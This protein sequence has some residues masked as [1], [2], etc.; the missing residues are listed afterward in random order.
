MALFWITGSA[1]T[2]KTTICKKLKEKGYVSYDIDDD[3]LARW[4]NLK[5]G[6]THP[7]SSVSK[8]QRTAEFIN[9]HGWFVPRSTA[10]E[11]ATESEGKLGFLCGVLDN[12]NELLDLFDG[13]VALN[14][15]DETLK[16]RLRTRTTGDWG[17]QEHELQHTLGRHRT[18]YDQYRDMGAKIIDATKPV[19]QVIDEIVQIASS[20]STHS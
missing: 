4:T 14:T 9:T 13:I 3:G 7:K 18:V 15:D 20:K 11:V 19:E 5:S 6:Y 10:E 1:G 12:Y 16:L 8:E 17:K 2:G